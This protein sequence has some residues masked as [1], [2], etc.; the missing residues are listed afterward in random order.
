[1]PLVLTHPVL[2]KR[3]KTTETG[4]QEDT[5]ELPVSASLTIMPS[6]LNALWRGQTTEPSNRT[7]RDR[8]LL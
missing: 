4:Q 8:L 2:L 1:M 3:N 5:T 6:R 7:P